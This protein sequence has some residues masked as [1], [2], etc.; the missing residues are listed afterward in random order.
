MARKR[1]VYVVVGRN[2]QLD[3]VSARAVYSRKPDAFAH[4][5][6]VKERWA[7]EEAAVVELVVDQDV[8][9]LKSPPDSNSVKLPE[10]WT[11]L[12]DL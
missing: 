3:N 1:I 12:S 11:H 6:N 5:A 4:V 2:K 9:V 10:G 7:E 8:G